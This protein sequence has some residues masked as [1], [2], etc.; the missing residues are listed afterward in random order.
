M[1]DEYLMNQDG[2]LYR[3]VNGTVS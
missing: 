2:H 3:G 1:S